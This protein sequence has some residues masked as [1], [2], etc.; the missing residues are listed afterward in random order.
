MVNDR[1]QL[2]ELP[3]PPRPRDARAI[4]FIVTQTLQ[5]TGWVQQ[6]NIEWTFLPALDLWAL[7]DNTDT[8][9]RVLT[10]VNRYGVLIEPNQGE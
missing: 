2:V 5:P 7:T 4:E 10:Y 9:G 1:G 3:D 8:T 6:E